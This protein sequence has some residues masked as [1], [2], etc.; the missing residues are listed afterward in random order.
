M[1]HALSVYYGAIVAGELTFVW[2]GGVGKEGG[3]GRCIRAVLIAS[4]V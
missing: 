3:Q 2:E 1:F 4:A